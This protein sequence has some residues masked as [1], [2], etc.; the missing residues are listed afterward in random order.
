MRVV[1]YGNDCVTNLPVSG[2]GSD[3]PAGAML[4]PGVTAGTDFGSLVLMAANS[5]AGADKI[6]ILRELHDYSASG[7]TTNAGTVFKTHPVQLVV[8]GRVIRAYY[9]TSVVVTCTQAVSTTTM[10]VTSL[11]D[12]IDGS[13]LY[14]Q[15]GTGAGQTNYLTA[16]ASGSCTLKAAFTTNLSTDSTFI[17][18]LRRFHQLVAL[19]ADGTELASY[20]A[21]GVHQCV[22]IDSFIERNGN[23]VQLDPTKHA[24]LTG[25]NSLRSI[26]FAADIMWRDSTPYSVD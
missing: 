20:D 19:N 10:T 22:V 6:G 26:R 7:D 2:A 25:L 14:V 12:N 5:T 9:S 17:K 23:I 21:V 1:K 8:P 16:A 3:I 18:I 24:A 13:F 4:K 11:E 15:A